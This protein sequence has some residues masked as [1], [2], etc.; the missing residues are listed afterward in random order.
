MVSTRP[1]PSKIT[2][3]GAHCARVANAMALRATLECDLPRQDL[4]TY[5]EDGGIDETT[6]IRAGSSRLHETEQHETRK[7]ITFRHD[8]MRRMAISQDSEVR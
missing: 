8:G 7:A 3:K 6:V 5:Q 2:G 4:G 1:G